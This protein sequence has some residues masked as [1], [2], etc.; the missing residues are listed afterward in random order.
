MILNVK[1][2]LIVSKINEI[3]EV[4]TGKKIK[5]LVTMNRK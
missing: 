5:H 2:R 4:A 1:E 3:M